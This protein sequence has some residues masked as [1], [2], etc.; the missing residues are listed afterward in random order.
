MPAGKEA[1]QQHMHTPDEGAGQLQPVAGGHLEVVANAEQE[2]AHHCQRGA[3]PGAH[4]GL[5]AQRQTQQRHDDH[6]QAGDEAGVGHAGEQQ[7]DLLQVDA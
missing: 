5:V 2:H 3:Q 1:H 4:A 7:A 6:V